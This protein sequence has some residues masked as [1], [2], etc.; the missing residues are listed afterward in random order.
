M[1]LCF[2][3]DIR[4]ENIERL[5]QKNQQLNKLEL[6]IQEAD[7]PLEMT[8]IRIEEICQPF[9]HEWNIDV[10]SSTDT[11]VISFEKKAIE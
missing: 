11:K 7:E 2:F 1:H 8:K 6:I 3:W 9:E 4:K 5:I 10:N